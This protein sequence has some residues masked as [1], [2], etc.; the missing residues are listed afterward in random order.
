MGCLRPRTV[1]GVVAAV[2][3]AATWGCT[4]VPPP[5]EVQGAYGAP[6]LG[7]EVALPAGE[8]VATPQKDPSVT[9]FRLKGAPGRIAVQV[10]TVKDAGPGSKKV[11]ASGLLVDI[12]GHK[13][14]SRSPRV[15]SQCE[16]IAQDWS[17]RVRETPIR[18]RTCVFICEGRVYDLYCW[19]KPE[20]FER[21]AALFETF[22][23]GFRV[24]FPEEM[25]K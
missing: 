18:A 16:A 1:F 2:L 14:I 6:S 25:T 8:W 19:S 24:K 10:T 11:L 22:L 7:Y 9:V 4:H 15:V 5:R 3:L 17:A 21:T 12:E 23:R 13:L 20:E